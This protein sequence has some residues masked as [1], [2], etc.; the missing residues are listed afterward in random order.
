MSGEE[1]LV[2]RHVL[3]CHAM[4]LVY[5]YDLIDEKERIAMGKHA[6]DCINIENRLDVGI[7]ARSLYL[8]VTNFL[9][10]HACELIIDRMPRTYR[11]YPALYRTVPISERSPIT[12]ISL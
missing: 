2:D 6:A 9:A 12:S 8:R 10:Y 11:H 5:L 1:W 4:L 3:D 7:I